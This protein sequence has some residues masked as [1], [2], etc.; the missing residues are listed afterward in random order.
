MFTVT[1]HCYPDGR[2]Q[3]MTEININLLHIPGWWAA[4][5]ASTGKCSFRYQT[6]ICDAD[7][8][9]IIGD[10]DLKINLDTSSGQ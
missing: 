6:L 1:Q 4:G 2:L 3:V 9:D 10:L 7:A 5:P 8:K